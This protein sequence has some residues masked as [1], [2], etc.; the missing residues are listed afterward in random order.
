MLEYT[1]TEL[2]ER[3]LE[4]RIIRYP[5]LIESG[6]RYLEHQR[7]TSSGRLDILF[8]DSNRTLVV[9]ELKVVEDSNM[10]IQALDYFDFV[11]EK[12]EGFARLHSKDKI[13]VERYPRLMLIAPSFT[14]I[15]INRCRW[16]NPDIQV[17]LFVYQYI[18]FQQKEEDTLV[19]IPLE[20]AVRPTILKKSPELSELLGYIKDE[21]AKTL[22]KRFLDDVMNLSSEITVDPLQWGKSIKFQGSVLCYWEPRQAFIRISTTNDDG[23]WEAINISTEENYTD[24]VDQVKRNIERYKEG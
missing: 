8:V 4:D 16:L 19:F 12:I 15:M 18:K 2:A 14:P 13:D 11:A 10:L 24:L 3:E 5:H 21:T 20:I 7:H 9:A 1:R 6:L 22:A 23:D 17:S